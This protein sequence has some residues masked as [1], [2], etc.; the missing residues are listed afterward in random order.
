MKAVSRRGCRFSRARARAREAPL[1]SPAVRRSHAAATWMRPWRKRACGV[2]RERGAPWGFPGFVGLPPIAVVEEVAAEEVGAAFS[3]LLWRRGEVRG[4][5]GNGVAV[6]AGVSDGVGRGAWAVRV[7]GEGRAGV[8]RYHVC[9][10][11]CTAARASSPERLEARGTVSRAARARRC[12]SGFRRLR[13]GG[14]C[15]RQSQ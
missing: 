11:S 5:V 14:R 9:L 13:T 10:S 15:S 4:F 7:G 12:G 3:P 8:T 1:R 6:A 2:S